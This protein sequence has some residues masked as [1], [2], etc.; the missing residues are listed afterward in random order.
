MARG[1]KNAS[2]IQAPVK[3]PCLVFAL[4]RGTQI[5]GRCCG[6]QLRLKMPAWL[7]LLLAAVVRNLPAAGNCS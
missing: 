6:W 1:E 3:M 4:E 7:L 5:C 2:P